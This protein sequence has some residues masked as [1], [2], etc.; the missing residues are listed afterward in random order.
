MTLTIYYIC[1]CG[2]YM[3]VL[4]GTYY[5]VLASVFCVI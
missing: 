5:V 1:Q 4:M 3:Y 2:V